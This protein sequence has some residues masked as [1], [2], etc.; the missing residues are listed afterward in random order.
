MK[1]VFL[2]GTCNGSTWRDRMSYYLTSEGLGYF[3]PVVTDWNEEAQQNELKAR[4]TCDYCLYAITPKKTGDYA[5]AE[6]IDDSNKRP[7]KTVL[8]L[9]RDDDGLRFDDVQWKSLGAVANMVERNGGRAFVADPNPNVLLNAALY[10][11]SGGE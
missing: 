2:G 6:V 5:I 11:S 3:N 7:E 4:E 9:L 1:Q 10:M 8:V